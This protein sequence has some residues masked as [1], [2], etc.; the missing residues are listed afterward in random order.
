MRAAF[1]LISKTILIAIGYILAAKLGFF[2][3][4]L[5]S[6]VSP[7]WP[8]EGVAFATIVLMGRNA[9][10]GI[11]IGANTSELYE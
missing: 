8:P 9:I 3:A 2:L 11:L 1:F 10:P 5:N 6:Q 4:F 7:V